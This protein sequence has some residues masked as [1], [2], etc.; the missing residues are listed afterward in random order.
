MTVV[1]TAIHGLR[2]LAERPDEAVSF[3]AAAIA[4]GDWLRRTDQPVPTGERNVRMLLLGAAAALEED[5]K[6]E[7]DTT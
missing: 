3:V 4:L 5:Y 2:E 6:N 1:E 7:G